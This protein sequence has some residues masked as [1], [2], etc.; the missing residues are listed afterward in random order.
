M[1]KDFS[2]NA[3]Y[4]NLVKDKDYFKYLIKSETEIFN[5]KYILKSTLVFYL[6]MSSY[7]K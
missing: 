6:F 7:Y 5:E 1:K 4:S 3:L 2:N